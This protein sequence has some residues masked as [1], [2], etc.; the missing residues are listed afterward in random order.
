MSY[1]LVRQVDFD[2]TASSLDAHLR[3]ADPNV[4]RSGCYQWMA[5]PVSAK[6]PQLR[7]IQAQSED[8]KSFFH[9]LTAG[10]SDVDCGGNFGIEFCLRAATQDSRY[11]ELMS[12]VA[13]MH[14]DPA[15]HLDVGHTVKIG[16]PLLAGS[17][18]D[19]VLVSL[20]YPYGPEFEYLHISPSRHARLLWLVPITAEEE[21]FRHSEGLEALERRF[22]MSEI[23][24]LSTN[25]PSVA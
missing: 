19:R 25:R 2:H 21:A 16:R 4:I 14:R 7:V 20:P 6:M 15:H 8:G 1:D 10:A 3:S 22:E 9:Y 18:L 5:G 17:K 13:F 12:L 11:I 24:F 23:D